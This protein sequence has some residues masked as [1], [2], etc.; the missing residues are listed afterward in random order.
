MQSKETQMMHL[1]AFR[2]LSRYEDSLI[3][4][5]FSNPP[6]FCSL[7]SSCW[8][9]LRRELQG[10]LQGLNSYPELLRASEK[11]LYECQENLQR[12]Q[13]KCSEK[14]ES[15]RQLQAQVCTKSRSCPS[16]YHGFR[17][18]SVTARWQY[19]PPTGPAVVA[20]D[21]A[22]TAV[23]VDIWSMFVVAAVS[24]HVCVVCE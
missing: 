15:L 4:C 13:R 5:L 7:L 19:C 22:F 1:S 2:S 9:Q 24:V 23:K 6:W 3:I 18:L 21:Y 17:Y 16:M 20:F 14:T 8:A 10:C 11:K 12:S